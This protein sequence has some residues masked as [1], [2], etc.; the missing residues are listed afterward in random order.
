MSRRLAALADRAA[1]A[2][3]A[4]LLSWMRRRGI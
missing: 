2:V 1:T 4:A 3:L